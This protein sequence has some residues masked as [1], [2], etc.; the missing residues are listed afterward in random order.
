MAVFGPDWLDAD[1][2]RQWSLSVSIACYCTS[3]DWS[4]PFVQTLGRFLP[5]GQLTLRG[6]QG[7]S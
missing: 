4:P 5:Y 2:T 1:L 7:N 3:L 6:R